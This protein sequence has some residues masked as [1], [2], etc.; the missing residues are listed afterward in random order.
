MGRHI[1]LIT[2]TQLLAAMSESQLAAPR[3]C[4][5]PASKMMA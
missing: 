2:G 3:V 1:L 4:L 5:K